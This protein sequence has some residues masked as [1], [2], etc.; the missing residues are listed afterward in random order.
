MSKRDFPA[1]QV[2]PQIDTATA[3]LAAQVRT[4]AVLTTSCGRSSGGNT[5]SAGILRTSAPSL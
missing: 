3:L 2:E 4:T 5:L 1:E